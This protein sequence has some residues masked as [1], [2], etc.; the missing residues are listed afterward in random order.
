MYDK[1]RINVIIEDMR[2]YLEELRNMDIKRIE[3]IDNIKFRAASMVIFSVIN[4]TIDLADEIVRAGN[5]GFPSEYKELFTSVRRAK[6]I[7]EKMENKLKDLVI[8]RNKISHRYNIL[9]KEDIFKALKEINVVKDFIEKL[10]E[11]V[12]SQ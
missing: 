4:K 9:K 2:G 10:K 3:D 6:I 11:V 5:M 7:D 8:L 1:E 12:K